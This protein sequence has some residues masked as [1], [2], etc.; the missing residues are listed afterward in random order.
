MKIKA[1]P[2]GAP[3]RDIVAEHLVMAAHAGR[4]SNRTG[5]RVHMAT[6]TTWSDGRQTLGAVNC[7]NNGHLRGSLVEGRDFSAVTC[8]RC[9]ASA[10]AA[11]ARNARAVEIE[12]TR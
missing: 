2:Y 9:G 12:V 10:E 7:S 1:I 5:A 3:F 11:A 4:Y 6:L 8:K